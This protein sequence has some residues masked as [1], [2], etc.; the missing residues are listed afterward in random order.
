MDQGV[1]RASRTNC[2]NGR[3]AAPATG[4]DILLVGR[5]ATNRAFDGDVVAV[6][7]LPEA[8]WGVR[9][10]CGQAAAPNQQNDAAAD[11]GANSGSASPG[12]ER[13]GGGAHVMEVGEGLAAMPFG[14]AACC[15]MGADEQQ[16]QEG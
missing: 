11:E 12:E 8:E 3:I 15:D 13:D 10:V 14:P 9:G 2:Y 4:E 16:K 7:L 1:F 6:E 5:E